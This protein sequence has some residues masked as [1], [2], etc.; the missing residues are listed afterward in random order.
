[1]V[2][3]TLAVVGIVQP[4]D[5]ALGLDRAVEGLGDAGADEEVA[6]LAGVPLG[7]RGV[8]DLPG[9]DGF[10]EGQ[11][12]AAQASRFVDA[13]RAGVDA[14]I[15][16][17]AGEA[18]GHLDERGLRAAEPVEQLLG[19]GLGAGSVED[20][21][22]LPRRRFQGAGHQALFAGEVA[23]D[24]AAAE[25][26]TKVLRSHR[27]QMTLRLDAGPIGQV[28][29]LIGA[30]R[31]RYVDAPRRLD[32]LEHQVDQ[33]ARVGDVLDGL[34][35]G[36][37]VVT[38][39]LEGFGRVEEVGLD[40]RAQ[41]RV[42]L[43]APVGPLDGARVEVHAVEGTLGAH[44]VAGAGEV[45]EH[46]AVVAA[47]VKDAQVGDRLVDPVG[48]APRLADAIAGRL[49][50]QAVAKELDPQ[51]RGMRL[52]DRDA[53]QLEGRLAGVV[54][55]VAR[56][57]VGVGRM[58]GHLALIEAG[59]M[60]GRAIPHEVRGARVHEDPRLF[61]L[62]VSDEQLAQRQQRLL[63][64]VAFDLLGE[65]RGL[66][67]QVGA[68]GGDGERLLR[69]LEGLFGPAEFRQRD[70]SHHNRLIAVLKRVDN[71]DRPGRL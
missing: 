30:V 57:D 52:G 14:D 17:L 18:L 59:G 40:Q 67:Q 20:D 3:S 48:L 70:R 34:E 55:V 54:A 45:G 58:Q 4:E 63:G 28:A 41:L 7:S 29:P 68:V 53:L 71:Q 27:P 16:P 65:H 61:V 50:G 37:R 10:V 23:D 43:A 11:M 66:A 31:R 25:Q 56:V 62:V 9:D 33:G 38:A 19:R 64:F 26:V 44:A 69:F 46:P 5:A 36:D 42:V 49:F 8:E 6:G 47:E 15:V 22:A 60:D 1:M 2:R 12:I 13:G 51:E 32:H 21:L 39:S 35:A 24:A